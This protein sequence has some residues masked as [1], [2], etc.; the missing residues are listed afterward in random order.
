M[1]D[2]NKT[3]AS[4][5]PNGGYVV[6]MDSRVV[7]IDRARK[8]AAFQTDPKWA[9]KLLGEVQSESAEPDYT[10]VSG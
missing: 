8:Q 7:S 9:A 1:S 10:G 3:N 6:P 4:L 2:A 5:I